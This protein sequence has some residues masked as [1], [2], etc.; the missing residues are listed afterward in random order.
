[1]VAGE[2]EIALYSHDDFGHIVYKLGENH[3]NAILQ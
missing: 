3:L 2:I 1:V